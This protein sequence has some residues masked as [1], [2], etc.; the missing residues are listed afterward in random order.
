MLPEAEQ[1]GVRVGVVF[2]KDGVG[3]KPC[4]IFL[5]A[6][7]RQHSGGVFCKRVCPGFRLGHFACWA[8]AEGG[9]N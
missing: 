8:G 1:F 4:T 3:Q 6:A 5:R 9:E 7:F 2:P